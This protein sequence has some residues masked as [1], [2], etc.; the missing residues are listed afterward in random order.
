[1]YQSNGDDFFLALFTSFCISFNALSA[2]AGLTKRTNVNPLDC[3]VT[4]S[5]GLATG[6]RSESRMKQHDTAILLH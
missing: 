6:D 2:S 4:G 5:G 1:M 3:F